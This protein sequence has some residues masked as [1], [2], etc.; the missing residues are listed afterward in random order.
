MR[1]LYS[2]LLFLSL[3]MRTISLLCFLPFKNN[4]KGA[5]FPIIYMHAYARARAHTHTHTHTHTAP[6]R[7]SCGPSSPRAAPTRVSRSCARSPPGRR[8]GQVPAP[9]VTPEHIT[10]PHAPNQVTYPARSARQKRDGDCSEEKDPQDE[11]EKINNKARRAVS[12]LPTT[13]GSIAP[14]ALGSSAAAVSEE[15]RGGR[16]SCGWA[17]KLGVVPPSRPRLNPLRSPPQS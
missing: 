1:S 13:R 17:G 12:L 14:H 16:S 2:F 11:Q 6:A 3:E 15:M 8:R 7:D 10:L 5:L 4:N 9:E